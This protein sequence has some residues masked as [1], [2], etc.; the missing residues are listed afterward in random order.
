MMK[1]DLVVIS[2]WSNCL[3]LYC[4]QQLARYVHGR[5]VYVVQVGKSE[6]QK[7]LFRYYM[8]SDLVELSYEEGRGEWDWV[9][10]ETVGR[11][12]LASVEGLWFVDHDFFL[13][14]DGSAWWDEMDRRLEG[15]AFCLAHAERELG[16]SVTDPLFWISPR[17][18]PTDIP[19]FAPLAA[20][21]GTLSDPSRGNPGSGATGV[22]R[23]ETMAYMAHAL[24]AR[25]QVLTFP[26]GGNT[27]VDGGP[28]ALPKHQHLGGL[29]MFLHQ[30]LPEELAE[31]MSSYREAYRSFYKGCPPQWRSI[32][33]P[34]LK[35]RLRR[36]RI[37]PQS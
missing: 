5:R 13:L 15:P 31:R 14:E 6:E 17:R 1:S 20:D 28:P 26:V 12:L 34:R 32:E 37:L 29:Y 33:D 3:A 16:Q 35:E 23:W 2:W 36:H 9:V 30:S 10:R 22:P 19:G 18:L 25:K 4:L 27:T 21:P 7:R 8:P 11:E 24:R